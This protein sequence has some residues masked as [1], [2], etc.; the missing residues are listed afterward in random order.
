[1]SN[2][3][4]EPP[5]TTHKSIIESLHTPTRLWQ[6]WNGR[7]IIENY[8]NTESG[9]CGESPQAAFKALWEMVKEALERIDALRGEV[10]ELYGTPWDKFWDCVRQQSRLCPKCRD[11]VMGEG[12]EEE[13]C[14]SQ[15]DG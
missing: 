6:V 4:K 10:L 5:K 1:M 12:P 9:V 11:L 13:E 3:D 8:L 2:E 15:P 14:T 7:R